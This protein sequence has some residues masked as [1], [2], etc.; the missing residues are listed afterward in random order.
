[1]T[2]VWFALMRWGK[3]YPS[4]CG[5]FSFSH[6]ANFRRSYAG[7]QSHA[8]PHPL[9]QICQC[10]A[11]C[12]GLPGQYPCPSEL[13]GHLA[14]T[15]RTTS[16]EATSRTTSN[17]ATC[18]TTSNK[19]LVAGSN[20]TEHPTSQ[21]PTMHITP[22]GIFPPGSIFYPDKLARPPLPSMPFTFS[23][24]LSSSNAIEDMHLDIPPNVPS[25]M[26]CVTHVA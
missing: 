22:D 11:E 8:H 26:D 14:H 9:C 4:F 2:R 7:I 12:P 20:T 21:G 16:K 24:D 23:F 3:S 5:S 13:P 19:A 17:K 6:I 10:Q 15:G 25:V 18:R 1:M